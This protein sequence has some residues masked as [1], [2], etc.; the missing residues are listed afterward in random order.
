M[1]IA[2]L[3]DTHFG[4]RND[5]PFFYEYFK[6]FYNEWFFP[7]LEKHGIKYVIQLGD[8]FD[9]RKY[10]NFVT[11]QNAQDIF[12]DRLN[13]QYKSWVLTGNHDSY[14]KNTI[15]VNS[16]KLLLRQYKNIHGIIDPYE[17]S[18]DGIS[19]LFIPWVCEEN[20]E[21]V[22]MAIK[23]S[24]SQIVVGHFEFAGFDMYKGTPHHGESLLQ[25]DDLA[26]FEYVFSGHFH[27]K[28]SQDNI[29]YLGTPY[30]MTWTD[31]DD[32]KGIHL[33][34]TATR[35][36]TFLQNP[37]RIFH[38]ILYDDKEKDISYLEKFDYEFYKNVFAKVV[39]INKTNPYFFDMFI[40]K[41]EKTGVYKVEVVD[42]HKNADAITDDSIVSSVED[43]LSI[44]STHVN[45]L[46][47][48]VDKKKLERLLSD[49]YHE[50]LS[51][52]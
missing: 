1:K 25:R 10:I 3:G 11:L 12:L 26:K 44:L 23:I 8:L 48:E 6:K 18:F 51:I 52:E 49:L 37:Y 42:D 35:E 32:P 47:S 28:S 27:H 5:N 14:F 15:E 39:V 40:E 24:K 9:R 19:I 20:I 4:V 36:L 46:Q 50:A 34:D 38:K 29:H 45:Q 21:K 2:L 7:C 33:F 22:K 13:Q 43:T 17:T 31:Y 41:L 30:E 16:V